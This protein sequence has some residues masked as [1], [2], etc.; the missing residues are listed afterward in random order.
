MIESSLRPQTDVAGFVQRLWILERPIA[1]GVF[2]R[3]DAFRFVNAVAV[4]V[5]D[6]VGVGFIRS[7]ELRAST[8]AC[9]R[10]SRVRAAIERNLSKFP[11]LDAALAWAE[12]RKREWLERGW[13]EERCPEQNDG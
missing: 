5:P 10:T 1:A 2:G 3:Q 9:L 12:S 11:T 13:I 8:D 6:G 4:L 7:L